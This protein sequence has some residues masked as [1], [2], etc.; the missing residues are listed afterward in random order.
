MRGLGRRA[1]EIL[2][3]M[4]VLLRGCISIRPVY[5]LC[6]KPLR[7]YT[8]TSPGPFSQG[9]QRMVFKVRCTPPSLSPHPNRS[10]KLGE[11]LLAPQR[12]A[13]KA[14]PLIE[15][16]VTKLQQYRVIATR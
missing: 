5:S 10:P 9:E 4:L 14:R 11:G 16:F 12:D 6:E 15:N 1:D 2:R 13:P 8:S 7:V 3:G